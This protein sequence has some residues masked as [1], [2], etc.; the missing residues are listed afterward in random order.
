MII[1]TWV[2]CGSLP[3][4]DAEVDV[5]VIR[6]ASRAFSLAEGM[7]NPSLIE[8]FFWEDAVMHPPNREQLAGREAIRSFYES[9]AQRMQAR[10]PGPDQST[11]I[12]AKPDSTQPALHGRI[13]MSSGGDMATQWG[14]GEIRGG[15]EQKIF[16]YKFVTVWERRDGEWRILFNS[17][18]SRPDPTAMPTD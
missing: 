11:I 10:E 1:L 4:D 15:S 8:V 9:R 5:S 14:Q 2:G 3:P 6:E 17:W 13:T 12:D 7:G 18:N 16:Y